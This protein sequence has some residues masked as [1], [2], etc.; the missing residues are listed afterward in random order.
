MSAQVS[1]KLSAPTPSHHSRPKRRPTRYY[2]INSS[3][4]CSRT[5]DL[6]KLLEQ[7]EGAV[8]R[9]ERRGGQVLFRG[10]M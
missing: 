8:E 5:I 6:P 4:A 3:I 10:S 7:D 2:E 9:I 1:L